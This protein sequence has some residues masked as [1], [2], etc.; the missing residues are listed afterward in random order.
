MRGRGSF[1]MAIRALENLSEAGFRDAK[2]SVVVT[3]H[4]VGQLDDFKA[5]A[6]RYGAT[7]RITRLRPSGRGAGVWDELHPTAGRQREVYD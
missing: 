7:L 4:N 6:E 2:I 5:L 3:R 1:D